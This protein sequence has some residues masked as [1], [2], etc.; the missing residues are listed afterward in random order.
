MRKY[1]VVCLNNSRL[2][3]IRRNLRLLIFHAVWDRIE[4]LSALRDGFDNEFISSADKVRQGL[5]YTEIR[6]LQEALEKS[7][8]QCGTCKSVEN[9]MI[10]F[11]SL[12]AWHCTE[13]DHKKL[14]WFPR[15]E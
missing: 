9:D 2:K 14:I 8:C 1:R 15:L 6:D 12:K 13:C 11:P 10:Y 5:I 3:E 4:A 7:I